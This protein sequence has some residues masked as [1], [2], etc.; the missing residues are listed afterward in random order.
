MLGK[1]KGRESGLRPPVFT[2][3]PVINGPPTFGITQQCEPRSGTDLGQASAHNINKWNLGVDAINGVPDYRTERPTGAY[4]LQK[5]SYWASSGDPNRTSSPTASYSEYPQQPAP[6]LSGE[7]TPSPAVIIRASRVT[8]SV[9]LY[10]V[11]IVNA[12]LTTQP[13]KPKTPTAWSTLTGFIQLN[14]QRESKT[15]LPYMNNSRG[16]S[17]RSIAPASLSRT[18][19]VSHSQSQSVDSF[20]QIG[21]APRDGEQEIGGRAPNA[22]RSISRGRRSRPLQ[23]PS[24]LNLLGLSNIVNAERR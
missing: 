24:P 1:A 6:W 8:P 9:S 11:H 12:G 16:T 18:N 13:V 23:R 7:E 4:Q 2:R 22:E 20:V 3:N 14:S 21:Q 5:H 15:S 10:P 17:Q 19:S